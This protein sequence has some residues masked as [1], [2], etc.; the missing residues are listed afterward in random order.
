MAAKLSMVDVSYVND[1]CKLHS[2]ALLDAL[3]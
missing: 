2:A 3:G 1:M